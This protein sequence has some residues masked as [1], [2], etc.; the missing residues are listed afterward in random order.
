MLFFIRYAMEAIHG[1]EALGFFSAVSMVTVIM[2]TLASSDLVCDHAGAIPALREWAVSQTQETGSRDY[3]VPYCYSPPRSCRIGEWI[4]GWAFSLVF[5][6]DI[7]PH[8]YLLPMTIISSG[9]LTATIF[10]STVLI[11]IR[12]RVQM[13]L[14]MLAGAACC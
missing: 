12:K 2:T 14:A 1:A 7:L 4:G 11:A 13:L 6:E 8:M 9:V 10:L 5:N 3:R